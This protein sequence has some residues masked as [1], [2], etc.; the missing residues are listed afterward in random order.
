MINIEL[1]VDSLPALLRGVL[2]TLQIAA[3]SC[4]I[5]FSL[6]TFFGLIQS[7]S[8]SI[9]KS[10]VTL[11]VSLIRGTPMLV[12]IMFIVF[13]LP[14]FGVNIPTIWAVIVAIGLNSAA[15][16]S[17]VIRS[18]IASV[19]K[20]QIEA[21]KV[22]G[23]TQKQIIRF[24]VLP[25]AIRVVLPALGNE[26]ITLT[27]DS[28]LASIVGVTELAKEGSIIMGRTFDPISIYC[29]ITALYLI[30]TTTLSYGMSVLEQRMNRHVK[31]Y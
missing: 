14:Q 24:I 17:Q 15:Y 31:T 1:I 2:V 3:S 13:G 29:A 23:L 8:S 7:S 16:I 30:L 5:G 27:K 10:F 18:G 26:F 12:Q 25:Q 21:A 20:G 11:Y 22:L 9:G 6:G 4:L 28:S 19:S